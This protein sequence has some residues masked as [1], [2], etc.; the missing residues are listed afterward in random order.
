[1]SRKRNEQ[2]SLEDWETEFENWRKE[3]FDEDDYDSRQQSYGAAKAGH[4]FGKRLKKGKP[5]ISVDQLLPLF[6]ERVLI[7]YFPLGDRPLYM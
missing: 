5:Q 7:G 3:E 4:W 1:M 6:P 2:L